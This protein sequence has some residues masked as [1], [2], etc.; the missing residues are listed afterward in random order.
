ME[1]FFRSDWHVISEKEVLAALAVDFS[2]GLSEAEAARRRMLCGANEVAHKSG[3]PAWRRFASQ[4][5]QPLIYVLLISGAATWVLKGP[6]DGGVILAV[7]LVNAV[8]GFIQETKALNAIAALGRALASEAGV[9]RAGS[10]QRIAASELVPGDIVFLQSGDKV[11]ADLRLIEVRELMVDESALTGESLP[12]HKRVQELPAEVLLTERCNMAYSSTLVTYGT[13]VG[14]VTATGSATEIGRISEMVEA[15]GVPDTPLALRM[16]RFSSSLLAGII[17]LAVV[18]FVIGA[19][20]SLPW[21]DSLTAAIALAV[22]AIPEGLPAAI[23]VILA[24]GVS[25]MAGRHAIIRYLPAVETLGSVTVICSDKTGTLTRNEMTVQNIWADGTLY[26]VSGSGYNPAGEILNQGRSVLPVHLPALAECLRCGALCNEA[27]LMEENGSWVIHGDPTEA[28]L[29]VSAVKGGLSLT[30]LKADYPRIDTLPFESEHQ[31]MATLHKA[32]RENCTQAMVKGSPEKLLPVCDFMMRSDGE[33]LPVNRSMVQASVR[34]LAKQGLRV[35]VLASKQLPFGQGTVGHGDLKSGL[36]V[37]G[38]QA[39]LDPPRPEAQAA[40]KTCRNAGIA[41]KMITG[42]HPD[43]ARTIAAALGLIDGLSESSVMTG[44]QLAEISDD[45][46]PEQAQA[47]S[48][49]ARVTPEHKLRLVRALQ[50][51][52]EVAAMTGDGVNDAPALKQA[53]IGI[54]MGRAGTE[55]AREA[56]HM[57]LTDDNFATIEAAVEEGRAV[58]D[59]I[60]KFLAWTLPTNLGQAMVLLVAVLAGIDLPML[61]GQILWINMATSACL[62]LALAFEDKEAGLM[63]RPPR[64]LD[65][66]LFGPGLKLRTLVVGALLCALAFWIYEW[67]L[68]RHRDVQEARTAAVAMFVAAQIFF[69]FNCRSL[70]KPAWAIGWFSN[71]WL[72]FGIAGMIILQ[73]LFTY[74][75][76]LQAA[77]HSAALD[78]QAWWRILLGA[79]S[80]SV[81]AAVIKAL[82]CS[83]CGRQQ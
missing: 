6:V 12:V 66:P 63:E 11:P 23:T 77:F 22:S 27:V 47:C 71:R 82:Q 25:R 78:G 56:A 65:A 31:Y 24:I 79:V 3:P 49:F 83:S 37:L 41:V 53:N 2:C 61:P 75:P 19:L 46:L 35:L 62:G 7:V 17:G 30:Q 55:V 36:I 44:R 50:I 34:D 59:N 80:V 43:T 40:I 74:H 68:G 20:R 14:V 73:L 13:A 67:E 48:V 21:V 28:A 70:D 52:G 81:V 9:L 64:R 45:D 32:A 54:A 58:F 16:K 38:L 72:W 60:I 4:L 69:L 8:V 42:D 5:H 51:Q 76:L 15:A 26:Q 1:S 39:M 29:L 33:V 10:K 57:V 18:T